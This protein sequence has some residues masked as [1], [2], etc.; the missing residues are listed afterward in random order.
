MGQDSHR[1]AKTGPL[2]VSRQTRS[3]SRLESRSGCYNNA[4]HSSHYDRETLIPRLCTA[5]RVYGVFFLNS[6]FSFNFSLAYK[7]RPF[8]RREKSFGFDDV[9]F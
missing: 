9:I 5:K 1:T 2:A 3:R 4:S 7:R 6:Y 8:D